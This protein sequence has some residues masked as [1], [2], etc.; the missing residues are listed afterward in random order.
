MVDRHAYYLAHRSEVLAR[1]RSEREAN[2]ELYRERNRK[3][4][5]VWRER[6][7]ELSRERGREYFRRWRD[8][9]PDKRRVIKNAQQAVP[10]GDCCEFCDSKANLMRFLPD[11]DFPKIVITICRQCRTWVKS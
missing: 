2:P 3:S 7:L 10:L 9:N 6:N 11:S 5:R 4:M 8:S 1:A